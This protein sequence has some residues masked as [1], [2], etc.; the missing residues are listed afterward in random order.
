M[1]RYS[2]THRPREDVRCHVSSLQ[3]YSHKTGSLT[4][5]GTKLEDSVA[6][7]FLSHT[8]LEFQLNMHTLISNLLIDL[9]IVCFR[10]PQHTC[11]VQKMTCGRKFS[12]T[13]LVVRFQLTFGEKGLYLHDL[14]RWPH[15]QLSYE[16]PKDVSSDLCAFEILGCDLRSLCF[17]SKCPWTGH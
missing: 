3:L 13:T 14:S 9:F 1:C 10:V 2:S 15:V 5:Y 6:L 8:V 4:E 11:K 12:S 7:Q 17:C 16:D